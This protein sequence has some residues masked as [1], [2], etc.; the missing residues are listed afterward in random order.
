MPERTD[1]PGRLRVRPYD[2][3]LPSDR[4]AVLQ[5]C[6]KTGDA[7]ADATAAFPDPR[8]LTERYA[9]PYL[10]LEPGLAFVA[11]RE[12]QGGEDGGEVLGYVLGASDTRSFAA[13]FVARESSLRSAARAE[14][15]A[16]MLV[17]ELAAFPAHLHVD[18]LPSAQGQGGGRMLVETLL[19]RLRQL[20]VAGVHLG[21]DPR[22]T[23]AL[24]FYP[25]LGFAESRP[26]F[27]TRA[28]RA[29]TDQ[30]KTSDDGDMSAIRTSASSE[31]APT[32]QSPPTQGQR[33]NQ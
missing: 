14:H 32:I 12:A 25:R 8:E 18:L 5:I 2:P 19:D 31:I 13:R 24:A 6:L 7:G 30:P 22:N 33:S 23:G 28:L 1:A 10:D 27:F 11:E 29:V 21:V 20:G 4:Q 26:G 9:A 17:P 15:A 16:R 3:Q